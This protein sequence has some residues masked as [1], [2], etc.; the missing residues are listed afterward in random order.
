L[1]EVEFAKNLPDKTNWRKMLKNECD[2]SDLVSE[3]QKL[4]EKI[5]GIIKNSV[6][7]DELNYVTK[8]FAN[9]TYEL[10][11]KINYPVLEYPVKVSSLDLEKAKII[12]AKLLGIKGQYLILDIGVINIRKYSGYLVKFSLDV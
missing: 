2:P 3:K 9:D 6:Y 4:L 1:L 8:A 11:K 5:T 7:Q 10:V 12:E